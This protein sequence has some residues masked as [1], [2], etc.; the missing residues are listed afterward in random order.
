MQ[1]PPGYPGI[2]GPQGDPGIPGIQV[3]KFNLNN[4]SVSYF[5]EN[6]YI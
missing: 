2:S 6:N 5:D 3:S 1:G 4:I